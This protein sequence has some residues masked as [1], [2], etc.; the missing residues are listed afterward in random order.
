MQLTRSMCVISE[1]AFSFDNIFAT[2]QLIFA[3]INTSVWPIFPHMR[4]INGLLRQKAHRTSQIDE[5]DDGNGTNPFSW[6]NNC[7]REANEEEGEP[8]RETLSR[9]L[10]ARA[11]TRVSSTLSTSC[12]SY[13]NGRRRLTWIKCTRNYTVSCCM[14]R[15]VRVL[16]RT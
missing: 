16:A 9:Q 2:L 1:P 11:F 7:G 5:N 6:I 13:L 3:S 8:V 15:A 4:A 10:F 12:V 14:L